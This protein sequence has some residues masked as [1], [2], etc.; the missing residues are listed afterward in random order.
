MKKEHIHITANVTAGIFI[1]LLLQ[2]ALYCLHTTAWIDFSSFTGTQVIFQLLYV[3][4]IGLV[5]MSETIKG[6]SVEPI[7]THKTLENTYVE[8]KN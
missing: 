3:L 6:V 7:K 1:A 4:S 8:L 5:I 2:Q